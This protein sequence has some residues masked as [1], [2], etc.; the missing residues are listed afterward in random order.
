MSRPKKI[1]TDDG[2]Q[3]REGYTKHKTVD[4]KS[5]SNR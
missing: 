4:K 3:S 2:A 5:R 1:N